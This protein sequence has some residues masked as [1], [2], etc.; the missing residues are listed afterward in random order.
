MPWAGRRP[1]TKSASPTSAWT[2]MAS[3]VSRRYARSAGLTRRCQMQRAAHSAPTRPSSSTALARRWWTITPRPPPG[4]ARKSAPP[5]R[6]GSVPAGPSFAG[7]VGGLEAVA[8]AAGLH[9]VGVV[10]GEA[11]AHQLVDVVD[12]RTL[13]VLRGEGVD[14]DLELTHLDDLVVLAW[15]VLVEAHPVGEAGAPAGLDEDAKPD[16]LALG[17]DELLEL[18]ESGVGDVD[19]GWAVLLGGAG[20]GAGGRDPGP[21][22][23]EIIAQ[24][25]PSS[26]MVTNT[27]PPARGRPSC[28]SR[29]APRIRAGRD[30]LPR[31]PRATWRS[32][33]STCGAPARAAASRAPGPGRRRRGPRPRR[34]RP[35]GPP[36]S[37]SRW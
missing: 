17:A 13:E 28:C 2:A 3:S 26:A 9:R 10:D 1:L 18:R 23:T 12:L 29:C 7:P 34:S 31:W 27:A 25:R 22:G 24:D 15:G 21:P 33:S 35:P 36:P 11:A 20:L 5:T 4:R 30:R 8:A 16:R 19:H 6:R 32:S 37:G 14:V